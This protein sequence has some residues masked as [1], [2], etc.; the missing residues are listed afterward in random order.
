MPTGFM[1]RS[2][3]LAELLSASSRP[4]VYAAPEPALQVLQEHT[5]FAAVLL[6]R[7]TCRALCLH[8]ILDSHAYQQFVTC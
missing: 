4:A 5:E 3:M 2:A 8:N 1:I 7:C 6:S